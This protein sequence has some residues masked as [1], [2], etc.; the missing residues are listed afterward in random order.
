[1]TVIATILALKLG[2]VVQS[3]LYRSAGARNGVNAPDPISADLSAYVVIL[4]Q[5]M[6]CTYKIV[7]ELRLKFSNSMEFSV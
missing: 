6:E 3:S 5:H 4:M 1:M 2:N 7:I